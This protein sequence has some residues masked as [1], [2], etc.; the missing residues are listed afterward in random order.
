MFI[1]QSSRACRARQNRGQHDSTLVDDQEREHSMAE[2]KWGLSSTDNEQYTNLQLNEKEGETRC[3][4][5]LPRA[6][7]EGS[8]VLLPAVGAHE[9]VPQLVLGVVGC[10]CE[11]EFGLLLPCLAAGDSS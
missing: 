11:E 5:H 8:V 6:H 4:I 2:M 9:Y 1:Q 3:H 7:H 10:T